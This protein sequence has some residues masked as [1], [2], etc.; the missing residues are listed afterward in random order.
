MMSDEQ[1]VKSTSRWDG[2]KLA[3]SS[4]FDAQGTAVELNDTWTLSDGG[5]V[6]TILREA[7]TPQGAFT[8]KTVYNK[9]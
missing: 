2:E 4:K 7:K 3:T 9:Q 5:K 1:V 8:V 6:L